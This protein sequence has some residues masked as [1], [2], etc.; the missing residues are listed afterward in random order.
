MHADKIS[1]KKKEKQSFSIKPQVLTW[2]S[3]FLK[4]IEGHL[5][6]D[7]EMIYPRLKIKD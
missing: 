3:C 6:T 4:F 2:A 1:A 7:H 5:I